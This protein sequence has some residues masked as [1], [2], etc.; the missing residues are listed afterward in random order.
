[1]K[2]L[3]TFIYNKDVIEMIDKLIMDDGYADYD[4]VDII[5]KERLVVKLIGLLGTDA[6]TA[7]TEADNFA[8]TLCNLMQ[9][10][11]TCSIEKSYDLAETMRK[12]AVQ[13]FD[14]M[15]TELFHERYELIA[16]DRM[17]ENGLQPIIDSV[18]GET[19]WVR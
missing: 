3:P 12:N 9:Y 11:T 18:T 5:D 6:Y 13:Y 8:D 10:M 17:K 15:L 7:I 16:V 19:R 1:M 2:Q 4:S 14:N